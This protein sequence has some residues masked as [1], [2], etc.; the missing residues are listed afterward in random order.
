MA[1]DREARPEARPL[2][3]FIATDVPGPVKEGLREAAAPFRDRIPLAR[4]TGADG[5]HL[6]LKFLGATW[7]RLVSTVTDAVAA[8]AAATSRFDSALTTLGVFPSERRARVI[9]AGLADPDERFG[10]IVK[11]LDESLSDYFVPEK[12]AFTPHLTL[13]RLAPPRDLRE[14]VPGMVGTSVASPPFPMDELVLYRSHLSPK[15]AR[16]EALERF[17]F[18]A[19]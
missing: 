13:A 17:P 14:F 16:Y 1:R 9:W 5:W 2:R 18:A 19:A 3:L 8:A 6:T 10:K 12:R 4:W 7:P 11:I 15:G